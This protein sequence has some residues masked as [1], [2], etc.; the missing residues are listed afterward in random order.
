MNECEC[1]TNL[2]I[3][4]GAEPTLLGSR[5]VGHP[6]ADCLNQQYV[7]K[8]RD[9]G[10]ATWPQ[11]LRLG[12]DETQRALQPLGLGRVPGVDV[13]QIRQHAYKF[14]GHRMVERDSPA[15]HGGGGSVAS[16][17]HPLVTFRNLL[18][19]KREEIYAGL[20]RLADQPMTSAMWNE[21]EI[22]GLQALRRLARYLKPGSPSNHDM[23]HQRAIKCRYVHSKGG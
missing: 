1:A 17:D 5:C 21:A 20:A 19:L 9:D 22:S 11:R 2:L 3:L 18:G 12:D 7:A 8:S 13:N 23:K 15:Q 10:L 14:L 4:Q 16:V 6:G